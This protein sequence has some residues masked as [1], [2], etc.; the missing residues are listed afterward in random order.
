MPCTPW[1]AAS[2]SSSKS[3]EY[4]Q[5]IQHK[6][7]LVDGR[8]DPYQLLVNSDQITKNQHR[9]VIFGL[10]E[11]KERKLNKKDPVVHYEKWTETK[12]SS[13]ASTSRS[14]TPFFTTHQGA[15]ADDCITAL[16]FLKLNN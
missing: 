7:D 12:L 10:Q 11:F 4:H 13:Y 8:A 2:A 15:T 14:A 5:Y 6:K 3:N 16:G 9:M 1:L